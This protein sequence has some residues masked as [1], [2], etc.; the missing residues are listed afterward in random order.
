M[1]GSIRHQYLWRMILPAKRLGESLSI[2]NQRLMLQ[3]YAEEHCFPNIQ[4]YMDDGFSGADFNRPDF[5]RMMN[6]VECGKVWAIA[7]AAV[8]TVMHLIFSPLGIG[9]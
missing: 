8:V 3:K 5:K 7:G 9:A 6:D 2:E 4:F 1:C